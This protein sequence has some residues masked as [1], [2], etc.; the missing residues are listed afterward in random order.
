[1]KDT[2][3]SEVVSRI[4][5]EKAGKMKDTNFSEVIERSAQI[6]KRYHQLEKQL[7]D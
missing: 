1:M 7:S 5:N 4:Y 6:R 3:F 2:S